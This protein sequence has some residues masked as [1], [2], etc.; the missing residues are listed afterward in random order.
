M[1]MEDADGLIQD[2][3]SSYLFEVEFSRKMKDGFDHYGILP[4]NVSL[5]GKSL[6]AMP[7]YGSREQLYAQELDRF[8]VMY[9]I[10]LPHFLLCWTE[11]QHRRT[12]YFKDAEPYEGRQGCNDYIVEIE[13]V[14]D[15]W[16]E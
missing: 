6:S 16:H 15:V 14:Y 2:L 5:I 3:K 10:L 13:Y 11:L 4:T 9:I 1:S 8:G 12:C 7:Y